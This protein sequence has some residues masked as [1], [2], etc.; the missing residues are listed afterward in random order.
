MEMSAIIIPPVNLGLTGNRTQQVARKQMGS[1]TDCA[2]FRPRSHAN[3]R[4]QSTKTHL[5]ESIPLA[6]IIFEGFETGGLVHPLSP[7]I[8]AAARADIELDAT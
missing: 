7:D 1:R 3:A 2:L 6:I 8:G 4:L 5:Y